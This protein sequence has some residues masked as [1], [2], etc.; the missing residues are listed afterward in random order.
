MIIKKV[1]HNTVDVFLG[2]GWDFWGRFK[3]KF[4]KE[5]TQVFQINGTKFPKQDHEEVEM[6]FNKVH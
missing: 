5:H 2:K 4:G 6:R 1:N 3:I